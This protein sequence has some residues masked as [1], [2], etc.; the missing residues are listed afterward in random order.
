MAAPLSFPNIDPIALDLG[1][2]VIRWYAL[3]YIAGFLIGVSYIKRFVQTAPHAMTK[4]QVD[5]LL[6][7]VVIGVVLG[8]RIGYVLFYNLPVYLDDPGRI[9]MVWQGGMAFH[10]GM[11]GTL[12]AM[13][14]FAKRKQL[15]FKAIGD[16]VCCAV[17]VGLFFGRLANF[18]NAELYGRTTDGPMGIIFPTDPTQMP[19]HPSQL[20]EAL[21]EG[22]VLF[23]VLWLLSRRDEIRTRPGMLSGF[24]L[25]GYG[26]ARIICEF[27]REPDPQLGFLMFD[28]TM[29]QLLSVPMVLIGV[30]LMLHSRRQAS[31]SA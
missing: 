2:I 10:G 3:A 25:I 14:L 4:D 6:L 8:G 9:L 12:V 15:D 23:I 17:P 21:L 26:T 30:A 16:T 18:I 11:L 1:F 5:D 7:W 27:F 24:F 31:V 13:F 29:G 20:Y 22:L 19:R 28:A